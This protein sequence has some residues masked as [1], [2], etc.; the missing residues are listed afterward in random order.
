MNEWYLLS[1][2]GYLEIGARNASS[3]GLGLE[4]ERDKIR[5]F[6]FLFIL[7]CGACGS[8]VKNLVCRRSLNGGRS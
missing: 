1:S 7:A 4:Q 8:V 2:G 3:R 6:L 5:P